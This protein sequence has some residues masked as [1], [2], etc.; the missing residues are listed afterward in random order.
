[1]SL[2]QGA[3]SEERQLIHSPLR[4]PSSML[5]VPLGSRHLLSGANPR[6]PSASVKCGGNPGNYFVAT[7]GG[8]DYNDRRRVRAYAARH[9]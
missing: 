8:A 2:E 9:Y 3:G 7:A 6:R 1:M 5:V 4:A